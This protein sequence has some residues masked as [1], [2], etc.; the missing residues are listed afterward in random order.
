MNIIN[1]KYEIIEQKYD[2]LLPDMF[3]H[4]ELC[5]RNCY[6]SE[7]R[8]TEDSYKKFVEML[9]KSNHGA[10]LEHGTVY[11]TIPLG[12]PIDDPQY[13]WKMDIVRFFQDNRFSIVKKKKV[14]EIVNVEIKGYGMRT[15]A[16]ATFYFI[17]T[18]W[19]VIVENEEL[20]IPHNVNEY[21]MFL[22]KQ[23][24]VAGCS[25]VVASAFE[26]RKI[27]EDAV[28]GDIIESCIS[29]AKMKEHGFSRYFSLPKIL[30]FKI[31]L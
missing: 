19:R 14:N 24:K 3:R 29:F 6:K 23:A 31:V 21:A 2:D 22:A 12:T 28:Y 17:T 1:P 27:K 20:D 8:I 11:L 13:I 16:S 30:P 15:Q 9:E 10:M 5:G 26:A 4:I 25:G 7:D 18:N